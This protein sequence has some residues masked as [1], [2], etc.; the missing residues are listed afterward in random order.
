MKMAK[1]I[2]TVAIESNQGGKMQSS[3]VTES[4]LQKLAENGDIESL[5]GLINGKGLK[6]KVNR[7]LPDAVFSAINGMGTS[8][9]EKFVS[10][11]NNGRWIDKFCFS[12]I[13]E[14]L[15]NL[16]VNPLRNIPSARAISEGPYGGV[17]D[18]SIRALKEKIEEIK[19]I[20]Y[21][22]KQVVKELPAA[23]GNPS[24][25][26]GSLKTVKRFRII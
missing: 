22:K 25:R 14:G 18:A 12:T 19:I 24:T 17:R 23:L 26:G 2:K 10:F 6:Q 16:K 7:H 4:Q 15:N 8:Q 11:A 21:G 20:K 13:I 9:L 3:L 5:L 1:G